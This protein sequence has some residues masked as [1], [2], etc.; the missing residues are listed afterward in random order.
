ML[1]EARGYLIEAHRLASA[2]A[3]KDDLRVRQ[4]RSVIASYPN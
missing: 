2:Y 3:G 4:M 1:W